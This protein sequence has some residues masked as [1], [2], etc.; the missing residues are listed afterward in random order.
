MPAYFAF[1]NCH[2]AF[3]FSFSCISIS[4]CLKVFPNQSLPFATRKLFNKTRPTHQN[5]HS[6]VHTCFLSKLYKAK[7]KV[8][9]EQEVR[10]IRT[11]NDTQ[12]INWKRKVNKSE[13]AELNVKINKNLHVNNSSN[14]FSNH[15]YT[16]FS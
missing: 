16:S 3:T 9:R 11:Q 13:D 8:N 10:Q 1:Q 4:L 12:I 5:Q 2:Q 14:S 7:Y 6:Y 15:F